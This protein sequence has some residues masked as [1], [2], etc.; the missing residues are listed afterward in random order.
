MYTLYFYNPFL[1]GHNS[2]HIIN[3]IHE[4]TLS[5]EFQIT[6]IL[7]HTQRHLYYVCDKNWLIP[8]SLSITVK[9][10]ILNKNNISFRPIFKLLK[11]NQGYKKKKCTGMLFYTCKLCIF[12]LQRV[13]LWWHVEENQYR[14][15]VVGN[16]DV[17]GMQYC[18]LTWFLSMLD[19]HTQI[20]F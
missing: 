20:P 11:P 15:L 4:L 14:A 6:K 19:G 12:Q 2:I 1:T 5:W 10:E 8:S 9:K 7:L 18:F 17:W 3:L 13:H 16:S